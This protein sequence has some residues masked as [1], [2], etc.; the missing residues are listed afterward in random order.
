MTMLCQLNMGGNWNCRT[1]V[2]NLSFC[3]IMLELVVTIQ[4]PLV[5]FILMLLIIFVVRGVL[6][7][8][9]HPPPPPGARPPPTSPTSRA[10]PAPTAHA[11]SSLSPHAKPFRSACHY[12]ELLSSPGSGSSGGSDQRPLDSRSFRDVIALSEALDVPPK[13]SPPATERPGPRII[14]RS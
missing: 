2:P 3:K 8:A 7:G 13:P 10:E 9:F 11:T 14:L 5:Q 1:L 6:D 12:K 4:F